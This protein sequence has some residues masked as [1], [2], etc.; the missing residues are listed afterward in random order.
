MPSLERTVCPSI[1]LRRIATAGSAVASRNAEVP[2]VCVVNPR[3]T[4]RAV[5]PSA[6]VTFRPCPVEML[7]RNRPLSTSSHTVRV[8]LVPTVTLA[9]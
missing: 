8:P 3:N 2:V 6:T 5:C 1:R 4:V 9:S 7:T